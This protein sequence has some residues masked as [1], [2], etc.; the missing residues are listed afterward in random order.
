MAPQPGERRV[1]LRGVRGMI[2]DK[3]TKSLQEAAQLTYH[4]TL[5]ATRLVAKKESLKCEG[6]AASIEDLLIDAVVDT[7]RGFPDIN[8]R[9]EGRE[10]VLSEAVHLSVAMALP[11]NLLVAPTIFDA[12]AM[13]IAERRAA[14]QGLSARAKTNKLTV[15][16]M[17]GGT[18]TVSNLGLTRVEHFTPII[19]APQIAILGVGQMVDRAVRDVDGNLAWRPHMGLS[20]TCDHRAI[21]G[22]PSADFL[23][24]LC[25]HIEA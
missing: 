23:T 18:F 19:N 7:L 20:L 6:V 2:A 11:G 9:V 14:R 25:E 4:A 10:I 8:G 22:S 1:P 17:T 16:E 13:S 12:H 21:D 24:A 15:T 5:D 3:M